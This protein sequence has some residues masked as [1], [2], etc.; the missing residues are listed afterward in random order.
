M[1]PTPT[2]RNRSATIIWNASS[3][4]K[5]TTNTLPKQLAEAGAVFG[6]GAQA[7][8]SHATFSSGSI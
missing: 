8:H 2:P 1:I 6:S 4:R 3:Q 7:G 5:L